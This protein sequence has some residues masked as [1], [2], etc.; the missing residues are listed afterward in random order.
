MSQ[1]QEP[2]SPAHYNLDPPS[3]E[4][5]PEYD[6]DNDYPLYDSDTEP[7]TVP[8][9]DNPSAPGGVYLS[10]AD[11]EGEIDAFYDYDPPN[12]NITGDQGNATLAQDRRRGGDPRRQPPASDGWTWIPYKPLAP[13]PAQD[14]S[15]DLREK[16]KNPANLTHSGKD[17]EYG[18][19]GNREDFIQHYYGDYA[20]PSYTQPTEVFRRAGKQC[21]TC[22]KWKS[23]DEFTSTLRHDGWKI[24]RQC[25]RCREVGREKYRKRAQKRTAAGGG[26]YNDYVIV[27]GESSSTVEVIEAMSENGVEV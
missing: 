26:P 3:N 27:A 18:E 9:L 10:Q 6:A 25:G 1:Q 7:L 8:G 12:Q 19:H 11:G 20:E 13:K 24:T 14:I 21:A 4:W 16:G 5:G 23:P 22:H 15:S 2:S 17:L